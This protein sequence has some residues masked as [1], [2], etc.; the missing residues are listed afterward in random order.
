MAV[1]GMGAELLGTTVNRET[2]ASSG[3]HELVQGQ[4]GND[5]GPEKAKLSLGCLEFSTL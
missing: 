2:I 1:L 3:F 5:S 4:A